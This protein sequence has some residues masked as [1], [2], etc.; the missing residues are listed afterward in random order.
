MKINKKYVTIIMTMI[1]FLISCGKKKETV[2]EENL[3][4]VKTQK[5]ENSSLSLGYTASGTIKGIEEIPYMATASG[6][7]V[8]VNAKNGDYVDAGRLIISIDNQSARSNVLSA[9][10]SYNEARINYE[11]YSQLYN[12]RLVTETEYLRAKTSYESARASLDLANDV[13]GKSSITA[14]ISGVIANLNVEKHQQVSA[15]T[16]LFTIVKENEMK[17]EVGVSPQVVDKIKVGTEAKVKIDELGEE[18]VGTVYEVAS[19]A[20]NSTKQFLVKIKIVNN[21][22]IKSGMYGT[23]SIN[24]GAEQ[25]IIIP[26]N[27]IVIRGVEQV[28]YIVKDGVAVAVPIKISNQNDIYAAVTGEGL[29]AGS[30]LVID[31][32]NVLQANEKVKKVN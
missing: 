32:Q 19:T 7:I 5:I 4:P 9:S 2:V 30:E 14:D 28:V 24:T 20:S 12:K 3:R 25:G 22:K 17:L 1:V 15:G 23:A 13:N 26:K 16:T 10:A 29:V 11:K 21:G 8:I 31:G 27:A 18:V 6:E